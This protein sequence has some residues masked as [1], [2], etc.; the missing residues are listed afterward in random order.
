MITFEPHDKAI[1]RDAPS[2]LEIVDNRRKVMRQFRGV[3]CHGLLL[4]RETDA[5]HVRTDKAET[6]CGA[7]HASCKSRRA[8]VK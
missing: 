7:R 4:N 6:S 2:Q 5:F 8:P 1:L 3:T